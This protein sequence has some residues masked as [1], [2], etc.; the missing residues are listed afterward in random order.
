[1][2]S[3]AIAT[4]PVERPDEWRSFC[5]SVS[6]SE[7]AEAHRQFLSRLGVDR[8]HIFHQSGDA[9]DMVVLVWEGVDQKKAAGS[10]ED[11]LRNPRSEHER[12]L[13]SYVIP[14][15]HGLD[16]TA[17]PP[18]AI[19]KVATID[20]ARSRNG[21]RATSKRGT[22]KRATAKRAAAKRGSAKKTTAKKTATKRSTAKRGSATKTTAK[23]STARRGAAKKA[24][25]K[26]AT[27]TKKT[28]AKRRP[29]NSGASAKSGGAARKKTAGR[30]TRGR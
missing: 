10:F 14:S 3:F 5:K 22:P 28:A 18:P 1:M 15:L 12:F 11:L 13:V 23:R 6:G 30:K 9:G 24:T 26:R 4:L 17:G 27:A 8:E 29:A 20:T 25:A 2:D 7:R 19:E 21:R 16:S